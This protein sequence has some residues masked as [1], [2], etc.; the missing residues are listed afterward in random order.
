MQSIP[1]SDPQGHG[2]IR[3][4]DQWI[5]PVSTTADTEARLRSLLE[6]RGAG[7]R[8][9]LDSPGDFDVVGHAS[10]AG[11]ELTLTILDDDDDTVGHAISLHFPS[12]EEAKRFQNRMLV[13]GALVGTLVI[14]GTGLALTQ[15]L[16]DIGS[17]VGTLA[18]VESAVP[19]FASVDNL[20]GTLAQAESAVPGFASVDNMGGT[21]AQAES[22]VPGFA[23]VDNM[24]GTLVNPS[25]VGNAGE[26]GT[27]GSHLGPQPR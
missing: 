5:A 4:G 25:D 7:I 16:P 10:G 19:G 8:V 17:V 22:A 18:Q 26:S 15:A 9:R 24:G 21:L 12:L 14:A 1:S 27:G 11:G 2:P 23:S 3:D 20:G 6:R 13:T